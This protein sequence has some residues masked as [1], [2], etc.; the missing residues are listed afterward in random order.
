MAYTNNSPYVKDSLKFYFG[1]I[2]GLNF[3]SNVWVTAGDL[4]VRS[5]LP[6]RSKFI[7]HSNYQNMLL[8]MFFGLAY[9]GKEGYIVFRFIIEYNSSLRDFGP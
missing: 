1:E 6:Y 5:K 2:L 8:W 4:N 3:W 9:Q 7:L